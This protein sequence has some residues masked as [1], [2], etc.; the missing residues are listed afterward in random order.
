[1]KKALPPLFFAL[2][3]VLGACASPS[4]TIAGDKGGLKILAAESFLADIAQ[5]VAGNTARVDS[6]IPPGMDPH[7]FEPAPT[8]VVKIAESQVFVVNGG[9]LEDAWLQKTV[10][11]A[12]GK[13]VVIDASAGLPFRHPQPGETDGRQLAPNSQEKGGD[14]HFWLNPVLVVRYIENIRDGLSKVDPAN[15]E[16]Y[17]SNAASYIQ[18]LRNLDAWI[19]QQVSQVP[20]SQRLLVTNHESLGY[21]ADQYGFKIIGTLIPS[22]SS[23][24][25]PSAQQISQLVDQIRKSKVKAIFIE[26]GANAD[27]AD[28][29]ARETG[30]KVV[31]TLYDH[32]LTGPSGP[33]PNYVDMMRY[34]TTTIVNALK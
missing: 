32:S 15:Q 5:N 34:D 8:D 13:V 19:Q 21:F 17:A 25:S 14:P 9:G 11:N 28:Q 24:A 10:A 23:L 26:T 29:V 33:A 3:L 1:M 2:L 16:I 20:P 30:I 22:Y 18:K 27:L 4:A 12:G 7:V 6:L 31:G